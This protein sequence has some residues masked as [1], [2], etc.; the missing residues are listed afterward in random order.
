MDEQTDERTNSQE[1]Y[2]YVSL[3]GLAPLLGSIVMWVSLKWPAAG[4]C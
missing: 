3:C 4:G 2:D 1:T